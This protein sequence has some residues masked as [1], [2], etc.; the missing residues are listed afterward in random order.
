MDPRRGK[1]GAWA[2]GGDEGL[3]DEFTCRFVGHLLGVPLHSEKKRMRCRFHTLDD[4]IVGPGRH[5]Q[6]ACG[7]ERLVVGA[8]GVDSIGSEDM[9]QA[10]AG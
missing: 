9:G 8:V 6:V 2:G 10:G 4:P 1:R 7:G 3:E 5:L